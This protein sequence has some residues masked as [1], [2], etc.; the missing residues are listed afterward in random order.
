MRMTG[1]RTMTDRW[2]QSSTE[3][4][5]ATTMRQSSRYSLASFG[6]RRQTCRRPDAAQPSKATPQ[7][8]GYYQTSRTDSA[9]GPFGPLPTSYSTTCPSLSSSIVTPWSAEWWK[10]RSLPRSPSMN[11]KPRSET[12]LLILPCGISALQRRYHGHTV[13]LA[14]RKAMPEK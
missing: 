11:P 3:A 9:R 1:Y 12:N 13:A 6:Q 2:K 5:S 14:M 4:S 7:S 8:G 10:N